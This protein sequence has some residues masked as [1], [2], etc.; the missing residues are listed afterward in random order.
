MRIRGFFVVFLFLVALQGVFSV[1]DSY[2]LLSL[3]SSSVSPSTVY[4]GDN[5]SITATVKNNSIKT[6]AMD[7]NFEL[8]LSEGM[9]PVKVNAF[10]EEIQSKAQKTVIFRIKTSKQLASGTYKLSLK[11]DYFNND[12]HV[13]QT[14]YID[15]TISDIYRLD[16]S[17]LRLSDY[18]PHQGETITISAL[19]ENT[20]SRE[21]RNVSTELEKVSSSDFGNFIVFSDSVKSLGSIPV[22]SSKEVKFTLMPTEKVTP[23]VYSFQIDANCLDCSFKETEKF[24]FHVFGK[25]ELIFSGI[26]FAVNGTTGNS[27]KIFQSSSFS[28]SVQLDNIGEEKAKAVQVSIELPDGI[29]GSKKAYIGNIDEDDSGAAIFDLLVSRS[30]APGDKA[31]K[32]KVDYLDELGKRQS[33]QSEYTIYV[34]ELPPESPV[35]VLV[36]V[37]IILVILYFLIKMIFR[38]LA[39]RKM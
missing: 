24:S 25:P 23:G 8:V 19:I 34:N 26:D 39:M 11:M 31:I 2:Y 15:L 32:I 3:Q 33:I 38:Q 21:A 6:T 16:I 29:A 13:T 7:V 17:N 1:A 22:G 4:A 12:K 35:A 10:E 14:E 37:I 9:E 30:I 18:S 28:L 27:K 5:V 36:L 20:G